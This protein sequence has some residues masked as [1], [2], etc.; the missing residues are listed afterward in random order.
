MTSREYIYRMNGCGQPIGYFD[1]TIP[2]PRPV[3]P[4]PL[5]QIPVGKILIAGA[6][7]A[8]VAGLA[9]TRGGRIILLAGLIWFICWLGSAPKTTT[10]FV[11][12]EPTPQVR[13][14]SGYAPRAELVRPPRAEL[15]RPPR[16]ELVRLP[17]Q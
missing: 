6:S 3:A 10:A 15:V 13:A 14:Q 4:Q 11:A 17:N 16:A 7:I 12:P 5:P 2:E 1:L 9:S 8:L